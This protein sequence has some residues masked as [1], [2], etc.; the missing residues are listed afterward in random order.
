MKGELE[1]QTISEAELKLL[2]V[3]WLF[4]NAT[5]Q[6]ISEVLCEKNHWDPATIKT[7]LF[8][9]TKKGVLRT[10]KVGRSFLYFANLNE[11]DV[12]RKQ[13]EKL[14]ES[15]RKEMQIYILEFL[16]LQVSF[17]VSEASQLVNLI[18]GKIGVFSKD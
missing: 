2:Q 5:A 4:G 15:V 13:V 10:E 1:Q 12:L 8:R 6:E 16:I 9:L 17:S 14:L 7:F 11:Q 3:I 18:E